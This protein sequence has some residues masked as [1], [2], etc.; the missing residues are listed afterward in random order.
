VRNRTVFAIVELPA[1]RENVVAPWGAD[2]N[3]RKKRSKEFNMAKNKKEQSFEKALA[4]ASLV[5]HF[6]IPIR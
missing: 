3:G 5:S 6:V 2:G 4:I 1:V